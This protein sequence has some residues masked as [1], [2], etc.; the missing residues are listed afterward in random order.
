MELNFS[1]QDEQNESLLS[2]PRLAPAVSHPRLIVFTHAILAV[3]AVLLVF[4]AC[5]PLWSWCCKHRETYSQ[6]EIHILCPRWLV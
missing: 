4:V 1:C 5:L 3:S 6:A 2:K